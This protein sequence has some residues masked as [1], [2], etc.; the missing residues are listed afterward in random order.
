MNKKR[1]ATEILCIAT[2][3][4]FTA[5]SLLACGEG[6]GG[7]VGLHGE[8]VTEQEWKDEIS[9][10]VNCR[11]YTETIYAREEDYD[12]DDPDNK[13]IVTNEITLKFDLENNIAYLLDKS[14]MP[15]R[16]TTEDGE[17]IKETR[18]D[19]YFIDD[20]KIIS[21]YK[22]DE[23][24]EWRVQ[25]KPFYSGDDNSKKCEPEHKE[26]WING[27]CLTV[28]AAQLISETGYLLTPSVDNKFTYSDA[29]FDSGDGSYNIVVYDR[30]TPNSHSEYTQKF[31]FS[32]GRLY[33]GISK[34]SETHGL[35]TVDGE[36]TYICG[37]FGTTKIEV[38]SEVNAALE[39]YRSEQGSDIN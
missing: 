25:V 39:E 34:W 3:A 27:E 15:K 21:V 6:D 2:A 13:A 5:S 23:L 17:T 30:Q 19:Y 36:Y 24:G 20:G 26:T 4:A 14:E 38:P 31:F 7:S 8:S 11:N 10:F 37:D 28:Y 29:T 22:Y 35:S 16:E 1:F 32:G 9:A 12:A 33:G 18:E